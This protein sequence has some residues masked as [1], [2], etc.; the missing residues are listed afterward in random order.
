MEHIC[1]S[2]E[3]TFKTW[4]REHECAIC[5]EG[6]EEVEH[7]FDEGSSWRKCRHCNGQGT[8][9]ANETMFCSEECLIDYMEEQFTELPTP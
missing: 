7:E 3:K 9:T 5:E 2:C 8:Y 1:K 4:Q 6:T